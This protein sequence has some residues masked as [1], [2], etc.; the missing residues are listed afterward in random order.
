MLGAIGLWGET[1]RR[2][3]R[4]QYEQWG[5]GGGGGQNLGAIGTEREVSKGDS[6]VNNA[7]GGGGGGG[8]GTDNGSQYCDPVVMQQERSERAVTSCMTPLVF[9]SS[10]VW[11]S[12]PDIKAHVMW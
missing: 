3:V 2:L 9:I 1:E 7:G 10:R 4:G 12:R 5:G 8:R 11:V 6:G